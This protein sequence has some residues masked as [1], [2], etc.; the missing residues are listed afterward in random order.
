MSAPYGEGD[1]LEPYTEEGGDPGELVSAADPG[2]WVGVTFTPGTVVHT[3]YSSDKN[4]GA[5]ATIAL[6]IVEQTGVSTYKVKYVGTNKQEV[7]YEAGNVFNRRKFGLHKC[8]TG[9]SLCE[10]E[11]SL[12]HSEELRYW[13]PFQYPG[14]LCSVR[15]R[16]ALEDAWKGLRLVPGAATPGEVDLG[17]G[18]P[19]GPGGEPAFMDNLKA[20]QAQV[21]GK[22]AT[23]PKSIL[24]TPRVSFAGDP[25]PDPSL[26]VKDGRLSPGT[27][28]K[29]EMIEV[30]SRSLSRAGGVRRKRRKRKQGEMLADRAQE[31]LHRGGLRKERKGRKRKKRKGKKSRRSNSSST[32]SAYDSSSSESDRELLPPMRKK[33]ERRPGLGVGGAHREDEAAAVRAGAWT[34]TRGSGGRF[35]TERCENDP[36]L[37]PLLEN[38]LRV[39][40]AGSKGA[41]YSVSV[42]RSS[43]KWPTGRPGGRTGWPCPSLG[44]GSHNWELEYCSAPRGRVTGDSLLGSSR[45]APGCTEACPVGSQVRRK[46]GHSEMAGLDVDEPDM[47]LPEGKRQRRKQIQGKKGE[48]GKPWYWKEE[49]DWK[50]DKKEKEKDEKKKTDGGKS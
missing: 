6:L 4:G 40:A 13:A 16:R 32:S 11:G 45:G 2:T 46:V 33:A 18:L 28:V 29:Q 1:V 49:G 26:A 30:E 8:M 7:H 48:K 19:D 23:P 22:A 31:C 17:G 34:G 20:L 50:K 44:V 27:E 14:H 36:F 10:I 35:A 39:P 15:G 24:R 41:L 47:G 21:T 3:T 38:A 37:Q 12:H 43:Q 42:H 5:G 9:I 25:P